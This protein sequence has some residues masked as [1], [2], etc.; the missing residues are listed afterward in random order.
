MAS[1]HSEKAISAL[2]PEVFCGDGSE[3]G[4]GG[5]WRYWPKANLKCLPQLLSIWVF[6]FA[7]LVLFHFFETEFFTF[8]CSLLIQLKCL[9]NKGV[10]APP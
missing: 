7:V 6:G 9:T 8:A 3:D 2:H 1:A 5:G 10:D 4:V